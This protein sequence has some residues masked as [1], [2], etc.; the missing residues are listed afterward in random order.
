VRVVQDRLYLMKLTRLLLT[1][2]HEAMHFIIPFM[3]LFG[4]I[5]FVS[6]NYATIQIYDSIPMPLFLTLPSLA[7]L[8]FLLLQILFPYASNVFE[9]SIKCLAL[10]NWL[11]VNATDKLWIRTI[12]ATRPP[13]FNVGSVLCKAIF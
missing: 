7:I 3:F 2:T 5:I 11:R 6:C 12:R 10:L 8:V 4:E 9:N 1:L 13:R